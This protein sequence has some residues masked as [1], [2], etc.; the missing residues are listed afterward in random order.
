MQDKNSDITRREALEKLAK[1]S[2]YS[3]PTVVTLLSAQTSYAQT[4]ETLNNAT[5]ANRGNVI[6]CVDMN[7]GKTNLT[8]G[9]G[10]NA[11]GSGS[12]DD[13]SDCGV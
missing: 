9:L 5:N 3:A 4:S 8:M 12:G 7:F 11:G 1:L 2:V 10:N 6:A 13:P